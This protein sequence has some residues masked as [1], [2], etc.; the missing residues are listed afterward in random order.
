METVALQVYVHRLPGVG[1]HQDRPLSLVTPASSPLPHPSLMS[2]SNVP[3]VNLILEYLLY[4]VS[5]AGKI[6]DVF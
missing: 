3:W 2:A 4:P 1:G 5:Q 6:F